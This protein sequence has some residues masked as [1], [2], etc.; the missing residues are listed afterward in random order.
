MEHKFEIGEPV[1]VYYKVLKRWGKDVF[2][3]KLISS[4]VSASLKKKYKGETTFVQL[5][6]EAYPYSHF[7]IAPLT[8]IRLAKFTK[9]RSKDLTLCIEYDKLL[10]KH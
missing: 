1:Q 9:K 5:R 3:I 4:K 7:S 6:Q 8:Q 10:D 2:S